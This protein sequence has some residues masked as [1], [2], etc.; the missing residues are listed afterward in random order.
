MPNSVSSAASI[1]ELAQGEKLRTH[2][3][4]LFDA[5]GIEAY[6]LENT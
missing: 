3:P 6:A 4:S 5:P 2:S 1:A